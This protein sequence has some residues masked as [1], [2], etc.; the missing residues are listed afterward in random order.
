MI[1][2]LS[3]QIDNINIEILDLLC[4][5]GKLIQRLAEDDQDRFLILIDPIHEEHF[6]Q[7]MVNNNRGPYKDK[8]IVNIYREIFN[9]TRHL[10]SENQNL[11]V[12][13][14]NHVED[15]LVFVKDVVIGGKKP[16]VIAGPC[17]VENEE[18]I[19]ATARELH[20]LGIQILRGGA[21]KPRTSPYSFQG[22]GAQGLEYL[23]NA[24]KEN[25]MITICEI[26]D[27]RDLQFISEHVDILQIG[28][29]NM[30]N[31]SLLKE[32]GR[33]QR[34]VF[35]KRGMGSTIEELIYSAE[36]LLSGG[37]SH[38]IL[39]ERGIRTY[40]PWT[41]FTLDIAAIPILKQKTHLPVFSDV[42]HS[43]GQRSMVMPLARASLA[44]GANGIMVEV[45]PNPRNA[46]SD[47]EQQLDFNE[48]RSLLSSIE[49][50][51]NIGDNK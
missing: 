1:K 34:P 8:D 17:S 7:E 46:L 44:A 35:L 45:H 43:A 48:F 42:S 30:A 24:A 23:E 27:V 26:L 41:R 13:R 40:E 49:P 20:N 38:V 9:A 16:T 29:R 25:N 51:M 11:L 21:F 37:N 31:Y 12:L 6:L 50:F 22:L 2:Q 19:H 5:R 18:Q 14:E 47:R 36:Y 3:K 28:S 10:N 15:T 32:V 33:T 39:C 4:R